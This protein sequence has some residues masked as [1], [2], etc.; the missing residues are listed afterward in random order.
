MHSDVHERRVWFR[1]VRFENSHVFAAVYWMNIFTVME[2][3]AEVAA[4]CGN[5]RVWGRSQDRDSNLLSRD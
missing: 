2:V 1:R 5:E 4:E 3:S